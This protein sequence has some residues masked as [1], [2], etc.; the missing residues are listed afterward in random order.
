[1]PRMFAAATAI[2]LVSGCADIHTTYYSRLQGLG[3]DGVAIDAGGKCTLQSGIAAVPTDGGIGAQT[4][5]SLNN[6]LIR[7]KCDRDFLVNR[8]DNAKAIS[9]Y[10]NVPMI[11]LAVG[12]TA[13]LL[14]RSSTDVPGGI[15]VAAGGIA[16]LDA[17][18]QPEKNVD[19]YIKAASALD[20]GV[21][22]GQTIA[23]ARYQHLVTARWA[24]LADIGQASL[25]T[26]PSSD[27][28]KNLTDAISAANK[29]VT[30]ADAEFAALDD[31]PNKLAALRSKVRFSVMTST[32][33]QHVDFAAERQNIITAL[34]AATESTSNASDARAKLFDA[35][36]KQSEQPTDNKIT[37]AAQPEV[38][39]ANKSAGGTDAPGGK[40]APAAPAGQPATAMPSNENG[41]STA[42][43]I[44]RLQW[45]VQWVQNV[46]PNPSYTTEVAAITAC[47]VGL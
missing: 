31:A 36:A 28:A 23:D 11:G 8:A 1:M 47:A 40:P 7:L 9:D 10:F 37:Q 18:F 33:R 38:D 19:T 26:T 29:A 22:A 6:E 43:V 46:T 5:V 17:Y 12:A 13:A 24:L 42:S 35:Q 3:D 20:C 4:K 27:S 15:G 32:E 39:Q 2:L 21:I 41:A 44:A 14:Y 16:G 34:Q 25:H 30:S 45:D